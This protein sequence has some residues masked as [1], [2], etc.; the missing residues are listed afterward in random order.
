MN[1]SETTS[2]ADLKIFYSG[3]VETGK[4]KDGAREPE[5][6]QLWNIKEARNEVEETDRSGQENLHWWGE[7]A[8]GATHEGT[9]RLQIQVWLATYHKYKL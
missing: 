1:I 3:L 2:V 5:N 4:A 7:T 8:E 9:S 6:A